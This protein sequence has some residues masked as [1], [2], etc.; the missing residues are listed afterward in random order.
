MF[1]LCLAV[2]L[3]TLV[4]FTFSPT[5]F[6][7]FSFNFVFLFWYSLI[8][9][10]D[11]HTASVFCVCSASELPGNK[12][13]KQLNVTPCCYL[14]LS[15]LLL[16]HAVHSQSGTIKHAVNKDDTEPSWL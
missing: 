11:S 15:A 5:A 9:L 14:L 16:G 6:T 8:Q 12:M 3:L 13:G 10:C 1:A 2:V 7:L 4:P